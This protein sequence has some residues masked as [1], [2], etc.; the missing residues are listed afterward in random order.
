MEVQFQKVLKTCRNRHII[1]NLNDSISTENSDAESDFVFEENMYDKNFFHKNNN[2][3]SY[4]EFINNQR[5]R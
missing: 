2:N 3:H 5:Y 1:N 4:N